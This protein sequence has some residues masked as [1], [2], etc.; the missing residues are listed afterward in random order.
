MINSVV[1][2]DKKLEFWL[3]VKAIFKKTSDKFDVVW[4][5][6]KRILDSQLLVAFL[7]KLVESKNK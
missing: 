1:Q 2:M 6:R 7:L 4:Q 5:K 3:E